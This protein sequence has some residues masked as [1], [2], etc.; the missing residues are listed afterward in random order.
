MLARGGDRV[1]DAA[2]VSVAAHGLSALRSGAPAR[3]DSVYASTVNVTTP[4]GLVTIAPSAAGG[5]PNGILADLGADLRTIGVD[6][7]MPVVAE[8]EALRIPMAGVTIRWTDA[9]RWSPRM[10]GPSGGAGGAASR[11]RRR[12][13][14]AWAVARRVGAERGFGPLLRGDAVGDPFPATWTVRAARCPRWSGRSAMGTRPRPPGR[15]AHSS[16]WVMG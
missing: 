1:C 6:R 7:G 8:G 11:W 16:A 2:S 13:A 14:M 9:V 3:I 10:P 15:P 4:L 5:L 12:S